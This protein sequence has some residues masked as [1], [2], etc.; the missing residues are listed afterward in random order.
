MKDVRRFDLRLYNELLRKDKL[1]DDEWEIF[2]TLYHM[3]DERES[4]REDNI[5]EEQDD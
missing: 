1:T 2:K 4:F 3:E 5:Y